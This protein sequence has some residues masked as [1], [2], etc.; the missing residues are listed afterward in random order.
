MR[1]GSRRLGRP[2]SSPGNQRET[3]LPQFAFLYQEC[4]KKLITK[5]IM[6]KCRLATK[7]TEEWELEWMALRQH[8]SVGDGHIKN[9]GTEG[10]PW[11]S[12]GEDPVLASARGVGSIPTGELGSHMSCDAEKVLKKRRRKKNTGVESWLLA[13]FSGR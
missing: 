10:L 8:H 12:G 2:E 9:A 6:Q 11:C 4:I 3:Q 13:Y 7:L 1:L 5:M